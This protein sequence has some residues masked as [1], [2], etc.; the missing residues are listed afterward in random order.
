[1]PLV[2][3]KKNP[4][5]AAF[6][7][8]EMMVIAPMVI[9]LIG[10]FIALIVNLTGEVMS[11]RGSNVLTYDIQNAL[12]RIEEDVKLSTTFLAKTNTDLTVTKQ[13]YNGTAAAGSTVNFTN[14]DKATDGGSTASLILNS[15]VTNGSPL[16]ETSGL[17]YKKDEPYGCSNITEYSKN[18]PMT[19]NIVYF[20]DDSNTLWRRVLVHKDFNN[21]S[22]RCGGEPWQIPTCMPGYST[23]ALIYCKA[24]DEKLIEGIEAPDFNIE[25]FPTA[26]STMPSAAATDGSA[27]DDIRDAAT[28]ATSTIKVSLTARRTVAGRD[29]ERSSSLRI[30]RLDTNASAV[31]KISPPASAPAMP[32]ASGKV[33]NGHNVT[34][35]WPRVDTATSYSVDYSVRDNG[36]SCLSSGDAGWIAGPENLS[37]NQRT[38]TI[39]QGGHTDRVCIRIRS[40]NAAGWSNY[41]VVST[42]IPLWAPLVMNNG[43]GDYGGGYSGAAYTRT[44]SGLVML[45]GLISKSST[46]P[47]NEFLGT[48]PPDYRP[49]GGTLIF[50][51]TTSTITSGRVDVR[52]SGDVV[53]HTGDNGWISLEPV[54]FLAS[55]SGYARTS[56]TIV[57]PW[58]NYNNGYAPVSYA[59]DSS[60]R[61]SIQ[62]LVRGGV[63]SDGAVITNLPAAVAPSQYHHLAAQSAGSGFSSLGI[64]TTT[65]VSKGVGTNGHYSINAGYIPQGSYAWSNITLQNSWVVYPGFTTPQYIK[66]N[67]GVVHL[68]GLIRSGTLTN[69]TNLTVL[70][71]GFRPL[72]RKIFAVPAANTHCRVDVVPDGTVVILGCTSNAWLS[73]DSVNFIAE[74]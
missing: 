25:Y 56:P 1:M 58:V 54:R 19:T 47:S 8:V 11:S 52:T 66:M 59:Q 29:I 39:T 30:T 16:S 53:I 24:D 7:L 69:G 67:D 26:G 35:T 4:F 57:A 43:W 20:V 27:T 28:Q 2:S 73:L 15:L 17:V 3:R 45:K 55:N 44:K 5:S 34:F 72:E 50:G 21:P 41:S 12:N 61:V 49:I 48:L 64:S 14:V 22:L 31:A 23:A 60:G 51:V 6:T 46:A 32:A 33:T 36:A 62:G 37:N 42:L 13:G 38:Y 74:Q 71:V 18:T 10:S 63:V 70:P 40:N 68:K 9:L 65:V